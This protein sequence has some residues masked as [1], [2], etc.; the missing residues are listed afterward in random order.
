M[1][2]SSLAYVLTSGFVCVWGSN[3]A[4]ICTLCVWPRQDSPTSSPGTERWKRQCRRKRE[5]PVR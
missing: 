3:L 5:D 2:G 1:E 4:S